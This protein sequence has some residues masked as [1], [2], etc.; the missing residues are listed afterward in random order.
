MKSHRTVASE[1]AVYSERGSRLHDSNACSKN[2]MM[3]NVIHLGFGRLEV[4]QTHLYYGGGIPV[5]SE[6]SDSDRMARR[7]SLC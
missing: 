5:L 4:F 3:L 1:R 2:G 7:M 6:P